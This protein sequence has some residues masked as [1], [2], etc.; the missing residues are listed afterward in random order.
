MVSSYLHPSIT[1]PLVLLPAS[2]CAS[3]DWN[4]LQGSRSLNKT[5]IRQVPKQLLPN[6]MTSFTLCRSH[7]LCASRDTL[8]MVAR[9]GFLK[10]DCIS[11]ALKLISSMALALWQS[12][13]GRMGR[14][15][16]LRRVTHYNFWDDKVEEAVGNEDLRYP[17]RGSISQS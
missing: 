2:H 15:C 6:L 12:S 5:D 8:P 3:A 14:M 1:W 11:F 10:V 9:M 17:G 4:V 16:I 13:H 7:R